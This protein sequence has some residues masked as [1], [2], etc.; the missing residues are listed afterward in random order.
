MVVSG[1]GVVDGNICVVQSQSSSCRCLNSSGL[2]AVMGNNTLVSFANYSYTYKGEVY[3]ANY[4]LGCAAHDL[5]LAPYCEAHPWCADPVYNEC[6]ERW[7]AHTVSRA[8]VS[9]AVVYCA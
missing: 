4:G 8:F 7:C 9:Q 1:E 2:A 3:T 5:A 6:Y